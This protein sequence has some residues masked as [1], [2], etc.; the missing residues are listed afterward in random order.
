[1][2]AI[3]RQLGRLLRNGSVLILAYVYFEDEPGQRA[4]GKLL[5][6]D[7]ARR[8][9]ANIAKLIGVFKPLTPGKPRLC[10][11]FVLRREL[12][13]QRRTHYLFDIAVVEIAASAQLGY[14]ASQKR[15][16]R[17]TWH[18]VGGRRV[19]C[20]LSATWKEPGGW[21]L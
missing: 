10:G 9:A 13:E 1:V 2:I 18:Q 15:A 7:E 3:R 17:L 20:S 5:T 8:I 11:S 12:V 14:D 16:A 4:V 19:Q 21:S 6:Y